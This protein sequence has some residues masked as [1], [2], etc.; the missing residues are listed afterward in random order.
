MSSSKPHQG[1]RQWAGSWRGAA[2]PRAMSSTGKF[3]AVFC[4]LAV[5]PYS[6][7]PLTRVLKQRDQVSPWEEG[8][9]AGGLGHSAVWQPRALSRS[10]GHG[11]RHG[12][13]PGERG[14]QPTG[15]LEVGVHAALGRWRGG[16]AA[17]T[18]IEARPRTCLC[19]S[20]SPCRPHGRDLLN[21]GATRPG[22][23]IGGWLFS[24]IKSDTW[25]PPR[26]PFGAPGVQGLTFKCAFPGKQTVIN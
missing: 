15:P 14:C 21:G 8:D 25:G 23:H 11:G 18:G 10:H 7:T 6:G 26:C 24:R 3:T 12:R 13:C 20:P 16:C 19:G 4:K 2:L 22:G 1:N 5:Q 17:H 9:A